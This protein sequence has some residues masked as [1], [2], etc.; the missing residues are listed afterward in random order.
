MFEIRLA[1]TL[2]NTEVI[3]LTVY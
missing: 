3:D 2:I 1:I